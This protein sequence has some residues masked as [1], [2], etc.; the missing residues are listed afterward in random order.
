MPNPISN[1]LTDE[2]IAKV[3][4]EL[5]LQLPH[6]EQWMFL[7]ATKSLDVQAAPGCGKTTLA[8]AKLCV[9]AETWTSSRHGI[10]VLSH[11]NVAKDE[12]TKIVSS[13]EAGRKLIGYPHFIG[14]IHSF[15]ST[16]L[17][18]PALRAKGIELRAIDDDVYARVAE[19]KLTSGRYRKLKSFATYN[20]GAFAAVLSA[21]YKMSGN[22]L[23]ASSEGGKLPFGETADSYKE[24]ASLKNEMLQAGYLRYADV[25]PLAMYQLTNHASLACSLRTRFPFVMIDEA[26]D[27]DDDQ[28][29]LLEQVFRHQDVVL[30]RIGD[31]N[32]AIYDGGL[33]TAAGR[34]PHPKPMLLP[35]TMRF[36]GSIATVASAL[37][38]SS[39]LQ[40]EPN[41]ARPSTPVYIMLF[42]EKSI[43]RVVPT[44]ASLA[45]EKVPSEEIARYGVHVLGARREAGSAF[46]SHLGDYVPHPNQPTQ[47][48]KPTSFAGWASRARAEAAQSGD[49]VKAS[50]LIWEGIE[51]TL[52]LAGVQIGSRR[53]TRS[54]IVRHLAD[55]G[56]LSECKQM[57][58]EIGFLPTSTSLE[59]DQRLEALITKLAPGIQR[60]EELKDFLRY[61]EEEFALVPDT[62][63]NSFACPIRVGTI[64]SAKGETHA[65]TLIVECWSK[66][67]FDLK[68]V[69]P[70]IVGRH[71]PKRLSTTKTVQEAVRLAFVGI[72]RARNLAAFALMKEHVEPFLSDWVAAGLE[73]VDLTA[74]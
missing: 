55:D 24:F 32:Q 29:L 10:C 15:V 17:V 4:S 30:Q 66:K 23:T 19:R 54:R 65:A 56:R 68:E 31:V 64:H 21:T 2:A 44:F 49:A 13:H 12:I 14:T 38:H 59:W 1:F 26:Q 52:D 37:A 11:T 46:P 61:A 33:C 7:K 35:A 16:F 74:S 67:I 5:D 62:T 36:G 18:L 71:D 45:A 28:T 57:I 6:A 58:Y 48:G 9:L 50:A 73:V 8:A 34:F 25:Y 63:S 72:T 47:K 22:T 70:V 69:I 53:A 20:G 39:P 43:K 42:D 40:I 51:A 27:T 3:A 41:P 60:T